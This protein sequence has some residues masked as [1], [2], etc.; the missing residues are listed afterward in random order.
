MATLTYR[1]ISTDKPDFEMMNDEKKHKSL[2]IIY[3]HKCIFHI[4]N[5]SV[6][7]EIHAVCAVRRAFRV[8]APTL[9]AVYVKRRTTFCY[10]QPV[11]SFVP[12]VIINNPDGSSRYVFYTLHKLS[13]TTI[14]LYLHHILALNELLQYCKGI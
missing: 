13:W 1:V 10:Q 12:K 2:S 8:F 4:N 7:P 9:I 11:R 6:S 5:L 3:L 14:Y